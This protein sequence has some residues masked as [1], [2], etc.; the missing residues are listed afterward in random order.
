MRYMITSDLQELLGEELKEAIKKKVTF[1]VECIYVEFQE[2]FLVLHFRVGNAEE[3]VKAFYMIDVDLNQELV[4]LLT[5]TRCFFGGEI[6]LE[7]LFNYQYNLTLKYDAF[8]KRY[9]TTSIEVDS[10]SYLENSLEDVPSDMRRFVYGCYISDPLHERVWNR[11]KER[12]L[13]GKVGLLRT[14]RG[15]KREC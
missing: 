8:T 7:N 4:S 10:E 1:N 13:H 11:A 5:D 14:K 2:H 9:E 15:G 3:C 12:F 6:C